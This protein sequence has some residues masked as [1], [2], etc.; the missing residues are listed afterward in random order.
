MNP[1]LL[2]VLVL[3]VLGALTVVGW[4]FDSRDSQDWKAMNWPSSGGM[5][6]RSH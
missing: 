6:D 5:Q 3:V 4:A 1:L 2:L